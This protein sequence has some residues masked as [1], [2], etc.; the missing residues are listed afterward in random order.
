[1]L[2]TLYQALPKDARHKI[3]TDKKVS[4]IENRADGV[5]VYCTD[6]TAVDGTFVIGADGAHSTV[7]HFMREL[8]LEADSLE[9]NEAEPFLTSY[10]ALWVRFATT[11][12]PIYKQGIAVET[13]GFEIGT[14]C[15][16]GEKSA[17]IG[18]YKKLA[19]PTRTSKRYN[20]KDEAALIEEW[21]HLP[22]LKDAKFS[23]KDA[24]EARTDSG[25]VN[26]EEG[27][28]PHWS[29]NGRIVLVG[30]AA[31]KFTPSV[32][33][34]LNFGIIDTVFLANELHNLSQ[35]YE[36]DSK[37]WWSQSALAEAFKRYQE[38]RQ[39]ETID[40]C[41]QS[42]G[43]TCMVTWASL[44]LRIIDQY[45]LPN[46]VVQ[47]LFGIWITSK[48]SKPPAYDFEEQVSVPI[49]A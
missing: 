46:S 20:K 1:L 30:D 44:G 21:G 14:Q 26:L 12:M 36:D 37:L 39:Q 19:K 42:S 38:K 48:A 6:G 24:Y 29:W 45:V 8:A 33:S 15:F 23:L 9:V 32:G 16:C 22:L 10:Q 27:V 11:S 49:T 25:L 28:L 2:Y 17:T 41:Q 43:M 31:H 40:G 18:V 13:H 5:V 4:K 34:G 47:R 7:R 3:L 35:R